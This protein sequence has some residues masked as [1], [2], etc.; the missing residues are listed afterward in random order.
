M[1]SQR[2]QFI[3]GQLYHIFN[4]GVEKRSI[5]QQVS[6]YFRFVFCLY[7]LN[8]KKLIKMRD[9]VSERKERKY[10]GA[11]R[12]SD[13][14]M[15]VEVITFCL[16]PN[17]Y[18]LVLRQLV[19]GG[20]SLFMKKLADSYVGYFNLKHNRKRMGSLFQGRFKAVHV[21]NDR[22][23]LALICYIF[24]N[25]VEL[26]EKKWKEVGVKYI[27]RA[28][29]FLESYRWSNYLDCIGMPNF[30]SVTKRDF[31]MEFFGGSDGIK[32]SIEDRILYKTELKKD[33]EKIKDL[34][35]E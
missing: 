10:T 31:V 5:F 25:P 14:E 34:V 2:P 15:L 8:D 3:A 32:K 1:P 4:R 18:H 6:D 7:E 9:R 24:T 13:R 27:K 29:Q 26:I 33:F 20:I 22:Q 19:D 35:L 12:V 28:I 16:M 17:H 30:P 11:T 21:K 23:L